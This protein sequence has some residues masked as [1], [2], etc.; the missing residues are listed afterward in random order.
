MGKI[1]I[2]S[3]KTKYRSLLKKEIFFSHLLDE[4]KQ[5]NMQFFFI[6]KNQFRKFQKINVIVRQSKI[7]I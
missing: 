4:K 1:G 2:V 5:K 7:S 6:I 3:I